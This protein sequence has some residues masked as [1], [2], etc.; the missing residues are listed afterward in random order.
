M[1]FVVFGFGIGVFVLS[2]F[3]IVFRVLNIYVWVVLYLVMYLFILCWVIGWLVRLD[4]D[5]VGILFCV[6]LEKDW[7]VFFVMFNDVVVLLYD[8]CN[9]IGVL[10][11][12]LL[13]LVGSMKRFI[14]VY[15]V[16]MI[17]LLVWIVWLFELCIFVMFYV[18]RILYLFLCII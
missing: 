10:Y 9:G 17:V 16:G 18:L 11:I 8:R 3:L 7:I 4:E 14:L 1:F 12:G 6:K 13:C 5:S 2:L 15:F